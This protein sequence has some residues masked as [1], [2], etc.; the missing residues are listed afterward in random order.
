MDH[1]KKGKPGSCSG[2]RAP[3]TASANTNSNRQ[4][5]VWQSPFKWLTQYGI[6]GIKGCWMRAMAGMGIFPICHHDKLPCHVPTQCLRLA[7]LNLK[8][9]KCHP[10]ASSPSSS[11]PPQCPLPSPAPTPTPSGHAAATDASSAT[12]SLGSSSAPSGLTAAV[13]PAV[14]P[15]G[16]FDLDDKYHWE[17]DNVGVEY[18]PPSNVNTR[19][20]PYSPSCSHI[21]VVPSLST[22]ALSIHPQALQLCL[23]SALQHLL[24]KLSLSPIVAPL[25]HGC[26]AI[27]DTGAID[28]MVPDKSC[29]ISYKSVSGLLV[30][31]GNNSYVQVLG[32]GTAKFALNGKRLLVCN[33]LHV[34]VLAVPLY[35]LRTHFT[36]QGCG[37]LDTKESG[38]LV[39]FPT[40]VL[41]VDTAMDCHLSFDPI[42]HSTPLNTLHYVQLRCP[43]STYPSEVSPTLF[44]ATPSPA[45]PA[46][47]ED[48][49]DVPHFCMAVPPIQASSM[50]SNN[51]NMGALS[52]HFVTIVRR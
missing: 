8:L 28:H 10:V 36:Q 18:P 22:S 17:G 44:V 16:N 1:S 12:G 4:G 33:V 48:N 27:T 45:S 40:F 35:S 42:G 26:L 34:P 50:P 15:P 21:C 30:R 47:V 11:A 39:Y 49:D 37:F 9:I 23:L 6:K 2:P 38:F 20:V 5:K 13:A 14:H 25:F 43:S 29:F 19:I 46:V 31:K 41:S 7:E 24:T 32:H 51:I 3:A 52:T